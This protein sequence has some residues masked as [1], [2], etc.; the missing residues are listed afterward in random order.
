MKS[1]FDT[2][3]TAKVE[4]PVKETKVPEKATV[5]SKTY[6][7]L[8]ELLKAKDISI[9]SFAVADEEYRKTVLGA[10]YQDIKNR[11]GW[12]YDQRITTNLNL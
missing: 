12:Q 5:T 4:E 11:F 10:D 7:D 9:Q 3:K 1:Y 6:S 8:E 2:K